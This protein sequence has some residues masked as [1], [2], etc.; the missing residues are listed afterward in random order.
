MKKMKMA[1]IFGLAAMVAM[2]A[3]AAAFAEETESETEA[4]GNEY[5]FEAEYTELEGLE[6]LGVS[7]SP[8]GIGLAAE[9]SEA[10]N[11]FY[12][13]N[14][15]VDSPVTFIITSDQDA[16]ATLK[17]TVGSNILGTCTWDPESYIITVNG[18][19]VEYEEFTTE[20]GTDMSKQQNFKTKTIGE[21]QLVEGE[22]EIVLV[23]GENTY[24]SN[25]PSA[26][27]LDCIKLITDAE[28]SMEEIE[29]NIE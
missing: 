22:N 19:A 17:I 3:G 24:R 1:A 2:S 10:S 16:A 28:L 13:G 18:E 4:E 21:I 25:M 27:S 8:S 7:G 29:E 15:G 6:G 5:V 9:S 12:L 26:P 23:A 14:L 20:N 11:E